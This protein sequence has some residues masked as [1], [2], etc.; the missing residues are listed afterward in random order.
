LKAITGHG[1]SGYICQYKDFPFRK[2][3]YSTEFDELDFFRNIGRLTV[4]QLQQQWYTNEKGDYSSCGQ[5]LITDIDE[6]RH[7]HWKSFD[8]AY[9]KKMP[10]WSHEREYRIVLSS[11]LDS[12]NDPNNR[13]LQYNFKDL[14]SI[15]FGMKTP[16]ED[17][18]KII[19]IVAEKCKKEG[20]KQFDFYEM[21]YSN[22]KKEMY[23]R[24]I[25]TIKL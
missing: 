12:Y 11:G 17:R 8:S 22:M 21:A 14:E 6:W 9:L 19:D 24:K 20:I 4:N 7:R 15:I 23:T 10:E 2:M 1:S 25:L 5:H 13:L 18:K 3:E 16:K